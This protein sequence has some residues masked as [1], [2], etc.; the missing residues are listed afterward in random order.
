MIKMAKLKNKE[1][2]KEIVYEYERRGN[3]V[4]IYPAPG[5]NEYEKYFQ[6]QKTINKYLYK[7]L[8]GGDL[9]SK[10]EIDM[11]SNYK[12]NYDVPKMSSYQQVREEQKYKTKSVAGASDASTADESKLP[13]IS[14]KPNESKVVITGDD[15]LIEYVDRLIKKVSLE[16]EVGKTE[17]SKIENFITHYVW[18][19]EDLTRAPIKD[20]L[21]NRL[22]EMILRRKKLLKNMCKKEIVV[23]SSSGK[24]GIVPI[25]QMIEEREQQKSTLL[26][27]FSISYLEEMLKS[28]TKSIARD[29]VSTLTPSDAPGVLLCIEKAK[30]HKNKD[31]IEEQKFAE[32]KELSSEIQKVIIHSKPNSKLASE[33]SYEI[34][35]I[36]SNTKT[37]STVKLP[38]TQSNQ[39]KKQDSNNSSF[40]SRSDSKPSSK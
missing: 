26:S 19:N 36:V 29:V 31:K 8:F 34:S 25:A 12:L 4:R 11:K 7:V 21:Q 20:R 2:I 14:N 23:G 40:K 37:T 13:Q 6:Y 22:G 3:F 5:C 39:L 15:V 38:P 30:S 33:D 24:D 18:H 27:T 10:Q 28:T 1:L 16:N 17:I 35:G 32:A 9:I